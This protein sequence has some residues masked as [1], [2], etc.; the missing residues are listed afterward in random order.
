MDR[1]PLSAALWA[2]V[3]AVLLGLLAFAGFLFAMIFGRFLEL[4]LY[5]CSF[6][7][8]A[9]LGVAAIGLALPFR[10]PRRF[11]LL[12]ALALLLAWAVALCSCIGYNAYLDSIIVV[13]N[14][15]IDT[16]L[17]LAFR[18]ESQIPRLKKEAS[19]RFRQGDDLPAVDGA[20]AFFPLYSAFVEATYPSDIPALNHPDS[21][22]QY[23][24]TVRGYER[25]IYGETDILFAFAPDAQQ[26]ELAD[27]EGVEFEFIPLGL[28]GFVFFTNVKNPV[29]DLTA[30]QIR[31]IYAGEIT[32][33]KEL[34]GEDTKILPYQ[35]NSGSGSQTALVEF[36]GETPLMKA[37]G[38]LVNSLMW[39]IIEEVADYHNHRGAMG[40]S[41]RQYADGIVQNRNIKLFRVNGVTPTVENVQNGTYPILMPFYMVLRKG[42]HTR[43]V[44]A[45]LDWARSEEGQTLVKAAGYAPAWS[46][47]ADA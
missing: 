32:D 1:N 4:N 43:E 31:R 17:Y 2:A 10:K 13:D 9:A 5:Y 21:P 23:H 45:F 39:G 40:F 22:Y 3:S 33:W 47:R 35:R 24:N 38:E 20:A 34:G 6:V 18:P 29:D 11:T 7:L 44:N 26:K 36:M 25:L 27:L 8:I 30:E 41:F 19:L 12:G 42:A 46:D 14:S 28:E 15:N 37:P 16:S